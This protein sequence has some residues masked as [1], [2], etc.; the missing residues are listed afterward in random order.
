MLLD[1][2]HLRFKDNDFGG[3]QSGGND[4][5]RNLSEDEITIL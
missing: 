4:S 3:N 1:D 2:S 5:D